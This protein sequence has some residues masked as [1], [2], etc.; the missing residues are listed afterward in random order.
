M[1]TEKKAWSEFSNRG[2]GIAEQRLDS[3]EKNNPNEQ[4]VIVTVMYPSRR[5]DLS[6]IIWD[7][8]IIAEFHQ[9]RFNSPCDER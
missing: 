4:A 9:N 8:N 2:K 3:E 1:E 5:A 7:R 6:R